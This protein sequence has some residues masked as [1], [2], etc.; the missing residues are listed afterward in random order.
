LGADG[1]AITDPAIQAISRPGMQIFHT[2]SSSAGDTTLYESPVV[3]ESSRHLSSYLETTVE[4][5]KILAR[6]CGHN[7]FSRFNIDDLTTWKRDLA[8]LTG[9]SYAGVVP[10]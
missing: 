4:L 2:D 8:Y 1:V 7:H 6:A 9:V 3:T 10:L 5:M